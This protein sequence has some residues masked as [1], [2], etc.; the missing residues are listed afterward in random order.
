MDYANPVYATVHIAGADLSSAARIGS[1][2]AP[3]GKRARIVAVTAAVTTSVAGGAGAITI[4]DGTDVDAFGS[5]VVPDATAAPA[6]V[7][8]FTDEGDDDLIPVNS[9]ITINADGVPSAGVADVT[10]IVAFF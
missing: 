4:G 8:A 6:V 2:A 7:N 1:I 10:V 3:A 9:W 5:L